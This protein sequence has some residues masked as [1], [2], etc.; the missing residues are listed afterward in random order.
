LSLSSPDNGLWLQQYRNTFFTPQT[1]LALYPYWTE[2][3]F[4][5]HK[6]DRYDF[7]WG[8]H[9]PSWANHRLILKKGQAFQ[10]RFWVGSLAE[11]AGMIATFHGL[12]R[13]DTAAHNVPRGGGDW[14]IAVNGHVRPIRDQGGWTFHRGEAQ[15]PGAWTHEFEIPPGDLREHDWNTLAIGCAGSG[16]EFLWFGGTGEW[17]LPEEPCFCPRVGA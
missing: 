3:L 15:N 8:R 7:L 6:P 13:T 11:T 12:E 16:G 17:S 10:R 2:A 5:S 9:C 1:A 14:F 4:K